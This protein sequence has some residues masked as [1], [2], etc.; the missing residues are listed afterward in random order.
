MHGWTYTDKQYEDTLPGFL[1][2]VR[3]SAPGAQL[4]W[5]STTPVKTD[6]IPGPSNA[7]VDARNTI[8]EAFFRTHRISIDDQHALMTQH[9]NTYKDSVHFSDVGAAIQAEQVV[10]SIQNAL[11]K[12]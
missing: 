2:A 8:A 6:S 3:R 10:A 9:L 12:R 7:R 4:I 11:T 5:A 1:K